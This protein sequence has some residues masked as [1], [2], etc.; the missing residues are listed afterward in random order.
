MKPLFCHT[1][2]RCQETLT[3]EVS[4]GTHTHVSGQ[5]SVQSNLSYWGMWPSKGPL[6]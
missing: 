5:Q 1:V 6:K 2:G 4:R 3:L